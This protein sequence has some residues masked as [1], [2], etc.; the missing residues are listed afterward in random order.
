MDT[1]A[2]P[3]FTRPEKAADQLAAVVKLLYGRGRRRPPS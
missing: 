1:D 2:V 3:V